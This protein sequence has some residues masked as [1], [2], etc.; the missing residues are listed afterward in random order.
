MPYVTQVLGDTASRSSGSRSLS[1]S[2]FASQ[3]SVSQALADTQSQTRSFE[4]IASQTQSSGWQ[5]S[6]D[7]TNAMINALHRRLSDPSRPV[8]DADHR[9]WTAANIGALVN[10]VGSDRDQVAGFRDELLHDFNQSYLQRLAALAD[11]QIDADHASTGQSPL[12]SPGRFPITPA[13]VRG[14]PGLRGAV[15]DRLGA[16]PLPTPQLPTLDPAAGARLTRD[17]R[18]ARSAASTASNETADVSDRHPAGVFDWL[19]Q[20]VKGSEKQ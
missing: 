14:P 4:R 17:G 3:A 16:G 13:P 8:I 2:T 20:L 19:G 11:P 12:A 9:R 15:D 1:S 10:P 7:Y 5:S 6:T 18:D